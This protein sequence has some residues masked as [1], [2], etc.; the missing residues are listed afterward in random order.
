VRCPEC[1][2]PLPPGAG[3]LARLDILGEERWLR[4]CAECWSWLEAWAEREGALPPGRG[5][6]GSGQ[7]EVG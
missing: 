1:R 7:R 4:V 5:R 2:R 3:Y 6:V